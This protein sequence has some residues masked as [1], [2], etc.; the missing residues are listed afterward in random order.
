MCIDFVP[1]AMVLGQCSPFIFLEVL[2]LVIDLMMH[3][4]QVLLILNPMFS[5]VNYLLMY[6]VNTL[7]M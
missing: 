1:G 2:A 5:L 3:H 4:L 6:T 7:M